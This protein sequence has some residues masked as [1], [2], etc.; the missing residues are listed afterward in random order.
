MTFLSVV[1]GKL[2]KSPQ[3]ITYNEYIMN[4]LETN[5]EKGRPVD[6]K[7][8]SS[9]FVHFSNPVVTFDVVGD[10]SAA[11]EDLQETETPTEP[12]IEPAANEEAGLLDMS[13]DFGD[14]AEDIGN[15]DDLIEPDMK[16]IK[17]SLKELKK[18]CD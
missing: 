7:D 16:S 2:S 3:P 8:P 10:N 4:I 5:I 17:T 18:S 1:G 11:L 6:P 9:P 13:L 12:S 14:V 15:I